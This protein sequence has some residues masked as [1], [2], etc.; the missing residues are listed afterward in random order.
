MIAWASFDKSYAALRDSH[1]WPNMQRDLEDGYVPGCANCQRN[2]SPTTKPLGPLHPLP[3]PDGWEDL[4]A[5]DFMGPLSMEDGFNCIVTFTDRLNSDIRMAA[6]KMTLLAEELAVLFF[7]E[8]FCENGL[9]LDIVSDR[10]RLFMSRFWAA[11]H[12]LTGVKCKISTSYHPEMDGASERTRKTMIQCLHYHVKS[13]QMDWRWA[14]SQI[15]FQMMN[16]VNASTEFTP[17]QL[18]M[19]WSPC[20][21]PPLVHTTVNEVE[22]IRAEKVIS[23]LEQDLLEAKDN[24]LQAK[25]NQLISANKH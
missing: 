14:L 13:N 7:D 4:V 22:D 16:T 17:F 23:K 8:G 18:Q 3:I 19:G 24:M 20:L 1:Y 11:L 9:P 10:N 6:C 21:I 25:M 15:Y 12:K 2:K 5:I